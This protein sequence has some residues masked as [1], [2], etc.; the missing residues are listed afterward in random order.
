MG[1]YIIPKDIIASSRKYSTNS[2]LKVNV[3]NLIAFGMFWIGVHPMHI[4]KFYQAVMNP[5]ESS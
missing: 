4:K 5:Y 3:A 1:L 2:Y